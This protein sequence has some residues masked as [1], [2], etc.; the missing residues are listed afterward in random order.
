MKKSKHRENTLIKRKLE[1]K[2]DDEKILE[3]KYGNVEYEKQKQNR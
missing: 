3:K 2:I 1:K